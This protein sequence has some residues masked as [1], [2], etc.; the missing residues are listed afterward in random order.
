M[1]IPAFD[2]H[3]YVKRLTGAG[4]SES[5]A[6]VLAEEQSRLL[7]NHL[8]TKHDIALVQ[9]DI[10]AIQQNIKEL[11]ARLAIDLKE[12]EARMAADNRELEAKLTADLKEL[13]LRLEGAITARI[14]EAKV[15][16]LKWIFAVLL[17]QTAILAALIRLL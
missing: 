6:E 5:Q 12:L 14:A 13:E 11:E 1:N 16:M 4:M 3:H 9:S 15:E 2:T 7:E 8:A 17:G 10:A